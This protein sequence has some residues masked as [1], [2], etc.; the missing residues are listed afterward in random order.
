MTTV[1][2]LSSKRL[3]TADSYAQQYI[4]YYLEPQRSLSRLYLKRSSKGLGASSSSTT[5]NTSQDITI[6]CHEKCYS[7]FTHKN[8]LQ[9]AQRRTEPE[10]GPAVNINESQLENERIGETPRPA[11][12]KRVANHRPILPPVCILCQKERKSKTGCITTTIDK[13]RKKPSPKLQLNIP[14]PQGNGWHMTKEDTLE[15]TWYQKP[16]IPP[17]V[18][19]MIKAEERE[20]QQEAEEREKQR[21]AE[22]REKQQEAEERKYSEKQK[23]EKNSEKQKKER[24]IDKLSYGKLSHITTLN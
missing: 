6:S 15:I 7:H 24:K 21:K 2:V 16:V 19:K 12:R 8:T 23:K 4:N 1:I 17:Q 5:T 11:K 22:E 10:T 18:L 13:L 14:P 3:G 20:K 9:S